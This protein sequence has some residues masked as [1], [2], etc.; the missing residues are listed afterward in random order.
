MP[1]QRGGGS[2]LPVSPSTLYVTDEPLV[3]RSTKKSA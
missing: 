2:P 1:A 3:T